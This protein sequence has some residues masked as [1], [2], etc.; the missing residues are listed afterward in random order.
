MLVG[1]YPVAVVEVRQ[2]SRRTRR[3]RLL[4]PA[5]VPKPVIPRD[6]QW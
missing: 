6:P 4:L 5:F 2:L 3:P 1:E